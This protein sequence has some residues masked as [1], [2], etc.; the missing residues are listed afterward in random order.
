MTHAN[1]SNCVLLAHLSE[2]SNAA[3]NIP[4][5]GTSHI[6]LVEYQTLLSKPNTVERNLTGTGGRHSNQKLDLHWQAT[7]SQHPSYK[8]SNAVLFKA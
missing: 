3:L 4:D 8:I 5:D 1:F 7:Q 2:I 6:E